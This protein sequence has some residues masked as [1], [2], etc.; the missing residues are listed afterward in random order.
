MTTKN[1]QGSH[2]F[3]ALFRS[4]EVGD[5]YSQKGQLFT[6]LFSI[7]MKLFIDYLS[8]VNYQLLE[9]K[10]ICI[11][12]DMYLWFQRQYG[13]KIEFVDDVNVRIDKGEGIWMM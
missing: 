10:E 6:G 2:P 13:E 7:R 12:R 1:E 4:M 9:D 5:K 11:E 8:S 3:N